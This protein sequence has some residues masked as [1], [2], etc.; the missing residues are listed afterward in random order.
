MCGN[1]HFSSSISRSRKNC[2]TVCF[3]SQQ[4]SIV[5][6]AVVLLRWYNGIDATGWQVFMDPNEKLAPKQ[7]S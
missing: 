6:A 7:H 5:V 4:L 3:Q 2:L 1:L